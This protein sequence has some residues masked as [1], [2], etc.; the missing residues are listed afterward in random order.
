MLA[1]GSLFLEDRHH[2]SSTAQLL[3]VA[4]APGLAKGVVGLLLGFPI[5]SGPST[6]AF[7]SLPKPH[8]VIT[9]PIAPIPTG[10]LGHPADVEPP[11]APNDNVPW[12]TRFVTAV[13]LI[14][15]DG[16]IGFLGRKLDAEGRGCAF[17]TVVGGFGRLIDD[18]AKLGG[19]LLGD[20]DFRC[21]AGGLDAALCRIHPYIVPAHTRW[22]AF[23]A[24]REFCGASSRACRNWNDL[25]QKTALNQGGKDEGDDGE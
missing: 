21:A 4:V 23:A 6:K 1:F 15:S 7:V 25:I 18:L 5:Q 17:R 3:L 22:V 20:Q 14:L 10:L 16:S 8:V 12:P 9:F 11:V 24:W 2:V 13:V 19:K